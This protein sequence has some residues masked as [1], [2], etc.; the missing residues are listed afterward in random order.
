MPLDEGQPVQ[1]Q[2]AAGGQGLSCYDADPGAR[3]VQKI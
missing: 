1:L 3:Q 2:T